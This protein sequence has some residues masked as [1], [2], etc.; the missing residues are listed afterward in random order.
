MLKI[1]LTFSGFGWE[2]TGRRLI[3]SW[4]AHSSLG[5]HCITPS[6]TKTLSY[7]F[8][9]SI[10]NWAWTVAGPGGAA[11]PNGTQFFRFQ[12]RFHRKAPT[13]EVCAPRPQ[14]VGTPA[15]TGNPGSA[16]VEWRV[17]IKVQWNFSW[18]GTCNLIARRTQIVMSKR[19]QNVECQ[20]GMSRFGEISDKYEVSD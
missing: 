19:T 3:I 12:I 4:Y 5:V 2:L 6:S 8:L 18:R 1:E 17:S 20:R 7:D 13:S 16:A 11:A 14:C 10:W 15:S 9:K